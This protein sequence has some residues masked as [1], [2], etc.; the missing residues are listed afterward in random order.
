M[1]EL[2]DGEMQIPRG[3]AFHRPIMWSN[4]TESAT[5]YWCVDF[6]GIL[7]NIGS[8]RDVRYLINCEDIH[9]FGVLESAAIFKFIPCVI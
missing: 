9:F 2:T 7:V 5:T 1:K 4:V 6:A 3:K 8:G